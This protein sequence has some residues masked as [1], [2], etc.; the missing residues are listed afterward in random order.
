MCM[1][2]YIFEFEGNHTNSVMSEFGFRIRK[3]SRLIS[4]DWFLLGSNW[5]MGGLLQI[6][7]S[8][9]SQ[10]FIWFWGFGVEPW[11]RWR[12]SLGKKSRLI[13]SRLIPSIGSRKGLRRKKGF[14]QCN[15][16]MQYALSFSIVVKSKSN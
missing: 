3:E 7:T 15:K 16:G 12:L 14:L 9:R 1:C 10:H 13:S 6:T 2:V 8:K 11:L 5:K 4:R